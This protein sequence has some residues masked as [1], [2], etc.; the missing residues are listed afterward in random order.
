MSDIQIINK[1]SLDNQAEKRIKEG[2]ALDPATMCDIVTPVLLGKSGKI[3]DAA[4]FNRMSNAKSVARNIRIESDIS[5]YGSAFDLPRNCISLDKK[6]SAREMI[7]ADV[8]RDAKMSSN[9]LIPDWQSLWDALRID[10]SIRKAAR[11]TIRENFYNM[12][13]MFDSD[14]IFTSTEFFPYATS[15]ELHNG[16]GEAVKQGET[17]A[18]QYEDITHYIYATGFTWTLLADLFDKSLDPQKIS[19]AVMLAYNAKRDDLSMSPILNFSYTGVQQTAADATSGAERQELLYNTIQD[20]VEDL[21][22]R[23]DPITSRKI[24]ATDLV[25]L[26]SPLVAR[27]VKQVINGFDKQGQNHPKN[28]PA[29]EGISK[30]VVYDDEVTNFRASTLTYSGI[31]DSILLLCKKNR[32]MN[33]GIKRNLQVESDMQP[34][35]KTLTQEERSWYFAEGQQITGIQYTIQEVTLPTW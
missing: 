19:D 29:I 15:F 34:D 26:C 11:E 8:F 35:V 2:V 20:G 7:N 4:L 3:D 25:L 12:S 14:R 9:S 33:I 17:L 27:H 32:Y 24:D 30:I 10:I 23:S 16:E 1:L 5:K 31:G 22:Q 6:M 28:L 21:S 18:G 13:D